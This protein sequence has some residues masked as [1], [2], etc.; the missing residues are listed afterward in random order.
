MPDRDGNL[1]MIS[2]QE[3]LRFLYDF[4]D[5]ELEGAPTE[6]VRAHFEVC[7]R[8]FPHLR[9]EESFRATLQRACGGP[10]APPELSSR[11]LSALAEAEKG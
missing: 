9:L 8:C 1:E 7:Q 5:G 2:C 11:L 10:C 6:Q 3:A 4:L